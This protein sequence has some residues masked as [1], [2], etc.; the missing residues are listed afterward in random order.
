[1]LQ[2][3]AQGAT[4][5]RFLH[6]RHGHGASRGRPTR[7]IRAQR[8]RD[9]RST[10]HRSGP[11]LWKPPA[12]A[13]RPRRRGAVGPHHVRLNEPRPVRRL[14]RA[15]HPRAG[16]RPD[17]VAEGPGARGRRTPPRVLPQPDL[18]VPGLR[19][20]PRQ[21]RPL[22]GARILAPRLLPVAPR[23]GPRSGRPPQGPTAAARGGCCHPAGDSA[24]VGAGRVSPETLGH[25]SAAR[26]R[27]LE[28]V[29]NGGRS[30]A[31]WCPNRAKSGRIDA[32]RPTR[33]ERVNRLLLRGF[34]RVSARW[35]AVPGLACHAE[36][37]GFESLHP[38][39]APR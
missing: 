28:P 6:A 17:T 1:M 26:D 9:G 10:R 25:S 4:R 37:R 19:P 16:W 14:P 22:D 8:T 39:V 29:P 11:E 5:G 23:R 34:M 30:S 3:L 32:Y 38:L 33:P 13:S 7:P 35:A 12:Q 21:H 24:D 18:R 31:Q 20:R 36:G 2:Q 15:G 27:K